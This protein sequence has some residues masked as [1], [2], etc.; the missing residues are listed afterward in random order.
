MRLTL[1][2][3]LAYLDNTL[4]PQDVQTLRDKLSESGFATQ[5]VQRIRNSL[6]NSSLAAP[7]PQAVGPVEEANVISE[8][9]DSTLPTEQVAEIERACL[10][11]DPHLAEAAACHQILTMVLGRSAQVSPELRQRIYEL[12][13]K[14]I[15]EIAAAAGSFSSVSIPDEPLGPLSDEV[16]RAESSP[17]RDG[18][19]V[20][21]V[22]PADSGVSDAP[23][24]LREAGL[25]D[26]GVTPG[27]G[28]AIAGSKPRAVAE[29]SMIRG[30]S[31]RTSRIAPWLV[32]FALAAVLLFA[33]VQIF[34]PL[35]NSHSVSSNPN[36]AIALEDSIADVQ[37]DDPDALPME[38][39]VP[40]DEAP[41]MVDME[42]PPIPE[43]LS[44]NLP[45]A[46]IETIEILE[47]LPS[48]NVAPADADS[49]ESLPVGNAT[50]KDVP[51][52][53]VEEMAAVS[54]ELLPAEAPAVGSERLPAGA[55]G[56][57]EGMKPV[58]AATP[59]RPSEQKTDNKAAA[60]PVASE[61]ATDAT[62]PPAPAQ[63]DG[64]EPPPVIELAKVTT[65]D[66]L[67][68]GRMGDQPWVRLT[69]DMPIGEG[70]NV[71]CAPTFR[72][73]M[74][75]VANVRL[76]MIGATQIHW[77]RD[78]DVVTL[79]IDFGRV[80]I[81][82][83]EAD[84][85]L[86]VVLGDFPV[87]LELPD[88]DT[89]VAASVK[90][91]RQPGLDPLVNDNRVRH[92]GVL[93]VRGIVQLISDSSE[94]TLLTGQQWIKHGELESQISPI[95]TNPD[96]LDP[97][98]RA[99]ETLESSARKGLLAILGSDQPLELSLREA[100][101]FR[102][103]EVGALAA[104]TLLIM[105]RPDVYFGGDG[106]LSEA[107][108]RAYWPD[109]FRTLRDVFDQNAQQASEV[110]LS[111]ARMDAANANSLQRLLT[112]YS[113]KQLVEGGDEE[114]IR[115]LDSPS[116]EVRVLAL[117]NLH[118]ITGTTLYFRAD[119]DNAIRRAPEIKKWEV[120]LRKGDI[121]WQE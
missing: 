78:A 55:G 37:P 21:P 46:A 65:A 42:A 35:F 16:S 94:E 54:N 75:S 92:A 12:P 106:I 113:Q 20:K 111:I 59:D 56:A 110:I 15:E 50:Q 117:E 121:R 44:E 105:G 36:D 24:R 63:P 116:M 118:N 120:R 115:F 52:Q 109:H 99:E 91:L 8:Y 14:K 67:L 101:S 61:D 2:T 10:E 119:Q 96:W 22:G 83:T 19:P 29:S 41:P 34:S 97:P 86:E 31:I 66:T 104:R 47:T 6:T 11:S 57:A 114:L 60:G 58:P 72:G 23:T 103:A 107:K 76:T 17:S 74:E 68:V 7:S 49:A 51:P 18:E 112:G 38:I 93:T 69:K 87:R 39:E 84:A 48:P 5:L 4:E 88:V 80:L 108:Q 1:R 45:D 53:A 70:L 71:I 28:P 3:L 25:G 30:A 32:S 64:V 81:T 90:N 100:T 95:E 26:A 79:H 27:G 73:E 102:R 40:I 77:S 85:S 82:A 33:L 98:D 13:D 43:D 9:L 89:V 62:P